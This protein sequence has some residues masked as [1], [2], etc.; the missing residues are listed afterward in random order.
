MKYI[1]LRKFHWTF[2]NHVLTTKLIIGAFVIVKFG[3]VAM[4]RNVDGVGD[5]LI[6]GAVRVGMGWLGCLVLGA[7]VTDASR[8]ANYELSSIIGREV[9]LGRGSRLS[10]IKL[11]RI[12]DKWIVGNNLLYKSIGV[13]HCYWFVEISMY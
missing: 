1:D 8:V 5:S 9:V 2:I 12:S 11:I 3:S 6:L 4:E 13:S 7:S 10:E